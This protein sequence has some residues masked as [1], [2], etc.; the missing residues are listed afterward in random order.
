M[1]SKW[2]LFWNVNGFKNPIA[3]CGSKK[4]AI[5]KANILLKENPSLTFRFAH[6]YQDAMDGL[7]VENY[8]SQGS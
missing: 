5:K 3:A 4:G 1:T 7:V 2:L 8:G 6:I